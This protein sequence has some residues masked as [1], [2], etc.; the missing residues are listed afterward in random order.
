[1]VMITRRSVLRFMAATPAIVSAHNLM[2]IK[3]IVD[4]G[5]GG[6]FPAQG[7]MRANWETWSVENAATFNGLGTA[8]VVFAYPGFS[9]GKLLVLRTETELIPIAPAYPSRHVPDPWK[10]LE[11]KYHGEAPIQEG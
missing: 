8:N 7:F 6:Q 2:P 5:V 4:I 3:P 10:Q 1:M 11:S 9:P